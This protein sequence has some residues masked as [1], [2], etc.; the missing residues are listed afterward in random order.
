MTDDETV[1]FGWVM[2]MTFLLTVVLGAP[3]IAIGSLWFE[4]GGWTG[5]VVF[6][7]TVAAAVWFVTAV[8]VYFYARR[9]APPST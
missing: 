5:R 8:C 4:I 6:A 7:T 3:L 1:D 9:Q 2:E